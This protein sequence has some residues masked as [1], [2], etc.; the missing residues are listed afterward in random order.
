LVFANHLLIT[1]TFG[2]N[3]NGM[4]TGNL[5]NLSMDS[6]KVATALPL[7]RRWSFKNAHTDISGG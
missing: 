5:K 4:K 7:S 3:L 2:K 6:I 1:E